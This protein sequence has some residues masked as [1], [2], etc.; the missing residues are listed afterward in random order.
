MIG[1]RGISSSLIERADDG[2]FGLNQRGAGVESFGSSF[3]VVGE[4]SPFPVSRFV[5]WNSIR[6]DL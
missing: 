6:M 4:M 5:G 1:S 3:F 2:F